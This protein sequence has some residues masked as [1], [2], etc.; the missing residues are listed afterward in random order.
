[1]MMTGCAL[2]PFQRIV[3]INRDIDLIPFGKC[4]HTSPA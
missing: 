2:R 4:G 1:M 3:F